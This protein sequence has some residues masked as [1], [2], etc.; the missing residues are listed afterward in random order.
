MQVP[1][2]AVLALEATVLPPEMRGD[3]SSDGAELLVEISPAGERGGA[4]QLA[5]VTL[6]E[7]R[8]ED[9]ELDLSPWAGQEVRLRFRT[10]GGAAGSTDLDYVFLTEPSLYTP[11]TRPRRLVMVFIDTLRPDHMSLYGYERQTSPRLAAWARD[12]AVFEQARSVAPWTLPSTRATLSGRQPELWAAAPILPELLGRAGW[13]TGAFV[14]NVYLSANF[15]MS[16]GWGVHNAVNWPAG[17]VQIEKVEAFLEAH[18]DR[19]AAVLLHF[20]DMHL[21]YSEPLSYRFKWAD[22]IPPEGLAT[23]GFMRGSILKAVKKSGQEERARQYVID[24]Y[25]QN[26]RYLDDQL[27]DLLDALGD[28]ATVVLFSDHGEELWDHDG[29]EHGHT[30]YEELLRVPL[31]IKGPDIPAGRIE[32]PVSLMDIS[33]TLADRYDLEAELGAMAGRS[34]LPAIAGDAGALEALREREHAVGRPLYGSPRWGVIS[35]D[36]KWTTH[37]GIERVVDLSESPGER[38]LVRD[39]DLKA[40]RAAFAEGIGREAPVVWRVVPSKRSGSPRRDLTVE[41]YHPG[42]FDR[43]W[44]GDD[45]L[46]RSKLSIEHQ[47][48]SETAVVT[49]HRGFSGSREIY[50]APSGPP[51]DYAGLEIR[52]RDGRSVVRQVAGEPEGEPLS[53]DGQSKVLL[54]AKGGGRSF[55]VTFGVAPVPPEQGIELSGMDPEQEDALEALGYQERDGEE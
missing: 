38:R 30:L 18:E 33:P 9:I 14:G 5:A 6:S 53:P 51:E 24:R 41:L 23:P 28:D 11:T 47:P 20:M 35:G 50:L 8:W 46:L 1:P 49:F 17:E 40:L 42:G 15:D 29:F 10:A 43:A 44:L 48:G 7:G 54:R 26:L 55:V 2:A 25:D 12:A 27:S 37:E 21:P 3:A 13:A 39:P 36:L 45:P 31:I 34:L 32:V 4:E 16:E 52:I 19:D 22:K